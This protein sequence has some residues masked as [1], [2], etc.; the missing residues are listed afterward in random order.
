M[1]FTKGWNPTRQFRLLEVRANRIRENQATIQAI[2]EQLTRQGILRFLQAHKELAKSALQSQEKKRIQ[3]QKQDHLQPEEERVRSTDPEAVGYGERSA[4]EPQVVVN[5]SRISSP[6]NKNITPTQIDH[7]VVTPESNINSD[8]LWLQM[9]QFSEQT[10]K[11]FSELQATHERMKKLTASMDKIVK[12]L[13]KGHSHLSKASEETNKRLK[14]LFEEQHHSKRDRDCLDQDINKLFNVYQNMKPQPQGH[15]MDN[16][17][18]QDEIKPDAMLMNKKRSQSQYQ[19]GDNMS[20]SE[21]EALKHLPEAS[22][23]PKFSQTGEYD[24]IQLIDYIDG[25]FI[26]VPSIPAYWIT[27]RINTAFKGHASIWYTELKEFHGRRNWPWWKSQIIQKYSNGTWI[28]QKNISFKNDKYSVDRDPYEWCLRQ[29]KRLTAI[30]PQMKIKMRNHKLLT[31]M[32]GELEHSVKYRF[33]HNCTLDDLANTVPYVRKRNTIGKY[34]PYKSSGF[35]EEQ[36][37]GVESKGKPKERVADVAKK[38]D[39]CHTC[40]STDHYAN[41]WPKAKKKVYAFEKVPEKDS[42]TEVSDSE[43]MGDAIKEQSD[44]DQ[45]PREEFLLEYKE[46]T[47]LDIK[48]IQ[49]EA[50]MPKATANKNICK[51]TQAAQTFLVTP[52]KGM[53]YIHGTATKLTVFIENAQHPLIFN[54]GAHFSIVARNYLDNHFPNWENQLL[55][56]R[57]KNF[58]SALGKMTSIGT[59]IKEIIIPHRK[60]NIRLNPECCSL[61]ELLNEFRERQFSTTLTSKQKLSLLKILGKNRPEFSNG[62]EPLGK[63]RGHDR[64]LYLG[65]ERPYPLMLRR[66]PYP[67]GLEIRKEIEKHINALRDMDVIRKIGHNEIVEITTPALIIW[68][69]GKSRL[70]GD[71]RALTNYTKADRYPIP[72]IP[73]ALDKLAKAKY[74]TKMDCMKGFHQNGVKPNSMKLL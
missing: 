41:N 37:F 8:S 18:H 52:T 23:W 49:L 5:N 16:P 66:P 20:Y 69:D 11:Q 67:E 28:W 1:V 54:S 3:G 39:S 12:P 33:N 22:S 30:D 9:S 50:G 70:C 60:G 71:V 24:H 19:D 56:T 25:L 4:Q 26:D 31:Q 64:E 61:E 42:P 38:K 51:H 65:V 40:G 15:V 68:N 53:A 2:E 63:I 44:D 73:H 45:D 32:R 34:T 17:Y 7:I 46:D 48:D 36:A 29:S 21:K 59:I 43:S 62:G 47:Q 35:K 13:Q 6:I 72:R 74:I 57:A 10:Q 58:K 55:P 27:D 14:L